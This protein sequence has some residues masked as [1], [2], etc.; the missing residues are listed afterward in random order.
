[1]SKESKVKTLKA[2]KSSFLTSRS[3]P[4]LTHSPPHSPSTV[5]PQPQA[6]EGVKVPQLSQL[7]VGR[8]ESLPSLTVKARCSSARRRSPLLAVDCPGLM[9]NLME[10]QPEDTSQPSVRGSNNVTESNTEI[11]MSKDIPDRVE[12]EE[13]SEDNSKRKRKAWNHFKRVKVEGIQ[14]AECNYCKARLKA[15]ASYGTTHLHKHY[16]EVCKK[17][18]RKI[19][20]RQS[21]M[22]TNKKVSGD[23]ELGTHIFNQEEARRELAS[24]V[25]LHDYPLSVVDHIGFRRYSTCLQPCFNMISRNTLKGDILKIYKDERTKYY[26]LLGKIKCRIAITT[27][28]WT[29]S[30]NKGFMVVTG[31]FIDDNWTLQNC[32]LRFLYVLAPHTTEVLADTLVEALMDWNIDRKV[33]TITIDNCTTNDAMINHLL[34]KLPTKDMPLDGKE[35]CHIL[36]GVAVVLDPRYK[37]PFVEFF[38]CKIY[39]ESSRFKIDEVRQNCYDLLFDYQSRCCTLNESS[40]SIGSLENT[41]SSDVHSNVNVDDSLDEFEQFVVSKTSG[42]TNLSATSELDMYLVESLLPRA[43]DFDIL[44]WW[45]TNG[46]KFPTL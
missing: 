32:I 41:M 17:R 21:F 10:S 12:I 33:S 8:R 18:P 40:S 42:A 38:F 36:M 2:L 45:K 39:H 16:E 26:N 23:Q 1:M 13:T 24:M 22:K 5:N 20:I 29:S 44:N 37:M 43:R 7:F 28:M 25:I 30:N 34:Q 46:V 3:Q 6:T 11:E 19:D 14:F 15:P 31:H 27:D 9:L 35:V 4:H